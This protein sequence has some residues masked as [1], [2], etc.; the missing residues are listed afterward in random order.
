MSKR[1]RVF[2][3]LAAAFVLSALYYE[4]SR[5][6]WPKLPALIQTNQPGM[7]RVTDVMD[8]DTIKVDL[9]GYT[10]TVRLIGVDTPET[11]DPR[12]LVQCFGEA[13]SA[14]TGEWAMGKQVRLEADPA[15]SDRDKYQ[16][17]LRY[18]YLED[19]RLLN[20]EIIKEGYGFAYTLFPFGKLEEFRQLE[21]VARAGRHGLWANCTVNETKAAKQTNQQ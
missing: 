19:G 12:K 3:V 8:G 4:A 13:A 5:A 18:V 11:K 9:G 6:Q 16:R 20:A 2:I 10:D 14:K 17:L 15:D 1:F 7:Y 21:D